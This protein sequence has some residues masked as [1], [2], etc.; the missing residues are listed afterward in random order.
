MRRS[1]RS[2]LVVWAVL[3]LLVAASVCVISLELGSGGFEVF[4][5]QPPLISR[6]R[7]PRWHCC[8]CPPARCWFSC[9]PDR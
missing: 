2:A 9:S 1:A 6:S 7:L 4:I 8:G 5:Q 3:S